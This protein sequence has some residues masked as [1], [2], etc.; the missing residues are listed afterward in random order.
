MAV[1]L[2]LAIFASAQQSSYVY[3][4][5]PNTD[6]NTVSE[7]NI[8]NASSPREVSRHYVIPSGYAGEP[9]GI[10]ID[11]QGYVWVGNQRTN[12]ILKMGAYGGGTCVDRNNNGIIETARDTSGNGIIDPQEMVSFENDECIL[13]NVTLP[14]AGIVGFGG[15]CQ[16]CHCNSPTVG[17]RYVGLEYVLRN[18]GRYNIVIWCTQSIL[19]NFC[20]FKLIV[21]KPNQTL[22]IE[23]SGDYGSI[24]VNAYRSG[25]YYDCATS[26]DIMASRANIPFNYWYSGNHWQ[27]CVNCDFYARLEIEIRYIDWF[28]IYLQ[29]FADDTATV[30]VNGSSLIQFRTQ[31]QVRALCID[32][33]D[34]VYVGMKYLQ[35]LYYVDKDGNIIRTIDLKSANC[36]PY[37]CVVDGNGLV[38]ITCPEEKRLVKYNPQTNLLESYYEGI[39]AF[40]IAPTF[41]KDGVI[42]TGSSDPVVRKVDLNGFVVW[43]SSTSTNPIGVTVDRDDNVYV[44]NSGANVIWKYNRTG[45]LVKTASAYCNSPIGLGFD[46][47]ENLWAACLSGAYGNI[48]RFNKDLTF[49]NGV[50]IGSQHYVYSDFTGYLLRGIVPY[51][52]PT[53]PP[54]PGPPAPGYPAVYAP[55]TGFL[56]LIPTLLGNP[57]FFVIVFGLAVAA[58]IER[59]LSSGGIAF[60]ITFLG[61][62]LLFSIFSGVVSWW[63]FLVLAA[64]II[65]GIIFFKKK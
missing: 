39:A 5:V 31:D 21:Q 55:P 20:K 4:F 43:S 30:F 3:L 8:T 12:S 51:I 29:F 46:E 9:S 11:H 33:Y 58:Q 25:V 35:V 36:H 57:L 60:V 59:F 2:F 53:P 45:S 23:T 32:A 56:T 40:G 34:N 41:A 42:I 28:A 18:P 50:T 54:G 26:F 65:G 17:T 52:P 61:I 10:A 44:A 62:L 24:V 19:N 16:G 22:E 14:S 38:W 37:S 27:S 7:I 64:L 1:F 13:K 47:Y 48:I 15:D 49:L 6:G 63:I